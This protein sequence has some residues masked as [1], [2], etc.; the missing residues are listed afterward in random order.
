M[1][2]IKEMQPVGK[3]VGRVRYVVRQSIVKDDKYVNSVLFHN[4]L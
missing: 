1:E 2:E 3:S 4:E